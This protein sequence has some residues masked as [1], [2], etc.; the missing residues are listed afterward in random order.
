MK[1]LR[2]K[3]FFYG[4]QSLTDYE[5]LALTLSDQKISEKLLNTYGSLS[6]IHKALPYEL[7]KIKG[8][9]KNRVARLQAS[10]EVSRRIQTAKIERGKKLLHS[11]DVY[12]TI[13][14]LF[15][16]ASQ[17]IFLV[18]P[19]DSKNRLLT[20]PITISQGSI[21]MTIVH[22]RE[23]MRH[24]INLNAISAILSHNHPSSH[25]PTPSDEDITLSKRIYD[26]GEIMGVHILDHVVVGNGEYFSFKDKG[27][28]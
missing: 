28:W 3:L 20:A 19:L 24:L 27:L 10:L 7:E 17:E 9:G 13:A 14:P 5:V 12:E 25:D 21:L 22:P 2:E 18:L 23:I 6:A 15:L 26:A 11:K 1:A 8:M 16:E 4:Q